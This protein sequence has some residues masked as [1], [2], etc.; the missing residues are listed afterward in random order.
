MS[1]EVTYADLKFQDTNKT[2]N[3]QELDKFGKKVYKTLKIEME[4]FSKLQNINEELQRNVS[5][6]IMNNTSSSN[7]L[8]NLSNTLQKIATKLCYELYRHKSEHKC[9]PCPTG[10]IWHEKSCYLLSHDGQTW[11][12]STTTC[13][14]HNASLLKINNKSA[15]DFIKSKELYDYW[16][17]VSPQ[18]EYTYFKNLDDILNSSAWI[19]KNTNDLPNMYC[20]YIRKTSVYYTYCTYG[21]KALCEKM[22]NPVK[23]ESTLT[24]DI[25]DER[26]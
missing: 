2:E 19:I 13:L 8:R 11:Q 26:M 3:T 7:K 20:G 18:K 15:L 14:S 24:S 22:A 6:Q 16:L 25:P 17:G 21:K 23:I 12:E 4:K 10:W 1:E 9:K 5:L